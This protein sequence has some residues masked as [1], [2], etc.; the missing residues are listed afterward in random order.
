MCTQYGNRCS[1]YRLDYPGVDDQ[2]WRAWI[3]IYEGDD[4]S[5]QLEKQGTGPP[6]YYFLDNSNDFNTAINALKSHAAS[7]ATAVESYLNNQ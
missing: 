7:R 5:M 3:N 6:G 4:G 1:H 2:N